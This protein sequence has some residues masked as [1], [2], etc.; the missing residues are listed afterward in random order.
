MHN[1]GNHVYK[2]NFTKLILFVVNLFERVEEKVMYCYILLK[3]KK[4]KRNKKL[5]IIFRKNEK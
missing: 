3:K 5:G 1:N 2:Y 4:L